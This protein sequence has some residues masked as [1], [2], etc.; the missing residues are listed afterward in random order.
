ML[1]NYRYK[2]KKDY[3]KC[4]F[5]KVIKAFDKCMES[6]KCVESQDGGGHQIIYYE[7]KLKKIY[8]IINLSNIL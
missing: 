4:N 6:I 2:N 3:F 1:Y 8:D 5:N 7:N